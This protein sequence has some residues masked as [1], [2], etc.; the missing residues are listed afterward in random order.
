MQ[1]L[2]ELTVSFY[3]SRTGPTINLPPIIYM[4]KCRLYLIGELYLLP[5]TLPPATSDHWQ[6]NVLEWVRKGPQCVTYEY[7]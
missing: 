7:V 2:R 3:M 1:E 4:L 6:A 5:I